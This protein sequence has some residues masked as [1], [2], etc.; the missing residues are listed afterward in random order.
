MVSEHVEPVDLR[1]ALEERYL[2]YAL[3]T[4]MHRA[5]PDVRDGLKP[6]HRRVLNA[7]RLLK[8]QPDYNFKKCARVVGDVVGRFHPHG[9]QAIYDALV[10]LAQDFSMRYPLIEGQGNFGNIDGD[11]AAAMR[12][13]EA[14]LTPYAMLIVDSINEDTIDFCRTYDGEDQEPLVM[15]SAVPNL[16]ANGSSGIAVGMSTSIPPHNLAELCDAALYLIQHPTAGTEELAQFIPGPDFPT[17]GLIVEPLEQIIEAYT[18]GRGSIRLRARWNREEMDRG[19]YVIVIT[20]IPYQVQKSRLIKKIAELLF[21]KKLPLLADVR[22]ESSEDIRIV[23]EPKNRSVDDI[24]LMESLFKLTE[25]EQRILLNMNVI[26]KGHLPRVMGLCALLGEW[27]EH[28]RTVLIRRTKFRLGKIERQLEIL[29]GYLVAYL[30]L[31]EII[32][33]I[34]E[35][36]KPKPEI[37]SRFGLTDMQADA[38]LDMRLR[39]LRKLEEVE[40]R[41]EH[42]VRSE[43]RENLKILLES[44]E[45]QWEKIREDICII[46]DRFGPDTELGHRRTSFSKIP[47]TDSGD[48]IQSFIVREP[49]TLILSEKGWVR[50][51]KG[52]VSDLTGLSF[53]AGDKLCFALK[54]ETTDKILLFATNGRFFIFSADRFVNGRAHGEHLRLIIDLEEEHDIVSCFV[55]GTAER[56]LISSTMGK[57]FIACE[58]DII[59]T[60]RKGK[61]IL[62]VTVPARAFACTPVRGDY[63]AVIGDNRKLL[64]FPLLELPELPRGKGVSLQKYDQCGGRIADIRSFTLEEGLRWRISEGRFKTLGMDELR[65]WIGHRAQTGRLAPRGF[66][67]N[68]RFE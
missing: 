34:R 32:R 16:L 27:L 29:G 65:E 40:I 28:R 26:S 11:N 15:P 52:H 46:R 60:T 1:Q 59:A 23:L 14:R 45:K 56:Y 24:F 18:S 64:V 57:C 54:V 48:I 44:T 66:P 51:V 6:V 12:Y 55:L 58:K 7:M 30:D 47:E 20:E 62:N 50:A 19:A 2:T 5:L 17:G 35:E 3:S 4:I 41:S 37:M 9:E 43:E 8:L 67:R 61:Q 49:I 33:I 63:I 22:D 25:L 10:R 36:D 38:I 68:N 53:K 31:D 39:S 13:T 21:A 42:K